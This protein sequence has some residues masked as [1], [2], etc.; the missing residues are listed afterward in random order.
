MDCIYTFCDLEKGS[1]SSK[2]LSVHSVSESR[3][4]VVVN[5]LIIVIMTGTSISPLQYVG[6][7][8]VSGTAR[9]CVKR[10]TQCIK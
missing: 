1:I 4:I 2:Q 5:T 9:A 3:M 8:N 7:I 6:C 10:V